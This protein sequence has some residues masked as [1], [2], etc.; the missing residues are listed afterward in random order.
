MIRSRQPRAEIRPTQ[1]RN[2]QKVG[3][4]LIEKLAHEVVDA[5]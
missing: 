5:V 4:P 3:K 1:H 2:E